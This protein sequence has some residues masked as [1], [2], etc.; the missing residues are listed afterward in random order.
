MFSLPTIESANILGVALHPSFSHQI[1]FRPIWKH[2]SLKGHNVTV[3]TTDPMRNSSLTN[4]TEI[5][6]SFAY[7]IWKRSGIIEVSRKE[8]FSTFFF[9]SIDVGEEIM[10]AELE[11]KQVKDLLEDGNRTFDLVIVEPVYSLG[12]GFAARFNSPLALVLS[13]DAF[14]MMHGFFGNPNHPILYPPFVLPIQN[15][16]TLLE[17]FKA[18]LYP[19]LERNALQHVYG[20]NNV[21][22]KKYFGQNASIED[23]INKASLLLTSV[24]PAFGTIRPNLPAVIPLGGGFHLEG[25]KQPPNEL[26]T[27]LDNA[28]EGVVYFSLGS[29]VFSANIEED[30]RKLLLETFAELPYKVIWKFENETMNGKPENV[31]LF[32]WLPQW[33]VLSTTN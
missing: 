29:N 6:L 18:F 12:L 24:N 26:K 4:L 5:D 25:P 1:V 31:H 33:D 23:L 13:T 2:L 14:P 21:L 17:R 8:G 28:T 20:R 9:K 27:F 30:K 32:K 19:F 15:P 10:T 22:L 16:M 3:L 11:M 7:D